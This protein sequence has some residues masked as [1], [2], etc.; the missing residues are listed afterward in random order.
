MKIACGHHSAAIS[1]A[2]VLYV[3]GTGVFGEYTAPVK[4]SRSDAAFQDVDIGGFFGAAI[5][6]NGLV[7]SWGS[8]T[9]GE[10]GVNDYQPRTSPCPNTT[11]EN[12]KVLRLSCGGSYVIAIGK[13]IRPRKGH[14][15][16]ESGNGRTRV[17]EHVS[18]D[19]RRALMQTQSPYRKE[20]VSRYR[21]P[22]RDTS[23]RHVFC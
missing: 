6:K 20:E 19:S 22:T 14:E 17:S 10:L 13:T 7:W 2:G 1:D 9:S 8:N 12:K 11:L 21:S 16:Y 18:G 4:F 3:W 15:E 23:I 5:D